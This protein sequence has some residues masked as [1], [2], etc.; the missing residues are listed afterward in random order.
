METFLNQFNKSDGVKYADEDDDDSALTQLNLCVFS[1]FP[2]TF[3]DEEPCYEAHDVWSQSRVSGSHREGWMKKEGR[4][5]LWILNDGFIFR[6]MWLL[7]VINE[8][9][10]D[11]MT[12][13]ATSQ[14]TEWL[15]RLSLKFW[16]WTWPRDLQFEPMTLC[17]TS[18]CDLI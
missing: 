12:L 6:Q 11:P 14:S 2:K 7:N 15:K 1:S 17:V 4:E 10:C 18:V 16:P 8:A 9:G 3:K 5:I 13:S